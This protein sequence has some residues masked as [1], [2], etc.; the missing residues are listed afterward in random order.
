MRTATVTAWRV[1]GEPLRVERAPRGLD[2]AWAWS[3]GQAPRL[4]LMGWKAGSLWRRAGRVLSM[5]ARFEAMGSAELRGQVATLRDR[6]RLGH[7]DARS[8]ELGLALACEA[9][10]RGVGLRAHRE[11]VMGALAL[12]EGLVA[13]MATGEGKT[14]TA[15]LA[16]TIAGW[17]G[18]GTHVVTVNDYLARRDAAWMKPVYEVCGVTVGVVSQE[19]DTHARRRAYNADVTYTTSKEAAA[20]FLRDRIAIGVLN[21]GGAVAR[22]LIRA[23]SASALNTLEV[24]GAPLQR[25]LACALVDEADSVLIDEAVTPL[26]LSGKGGGRGGD[27]EEELVYREAARIAGEMDLGRDYSVESDRR[28]ARLTEAGRARATARNGASI[29]ARRKEELV[30]QAIE[31]REHYRLGREYVIHDGRVV[32]VDEFTGR[33]MADR[34]WRDGMHQAIEA[35]EGLALR[36]AQET[37]AQ[38]S[39]QRFF[40]LYRR[41]SGMTGTAR[42]AAGELWR[43]YRLAVVRVPTHRPVARRER[44]QV[45]CAHESEKL[46]RVVE[47][48]RAERGRGRPVLIGTRSVAASERVSAALSKAGVEHSVL[49]A[50]RHA[51]EAAVIARAGETGIVTVATNMAGRGT[52]IRLGEGVAALGGLH[53][54]ATERHE[55]LRVDR[56][57]FGRAGRQGDPGS[58]RAI[59]S[60]EDELLVR[61]TPILARKIGKWGG[62]LFG[63]AQWRASGAAARMRIRVLRGD[64][65]L[66]DSLGFAGRDI[67][68]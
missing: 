53:V 45:V 5:W 13:E 30:T 11:Q 52:D 62:W 17:R 68:G 48:A 36:A 4:A 28:R 46:E 23:M 9:A 8:I 21:G 19:T 54:I 33:L 7:E 10:L 63:F 59:V 56:Q 3:V 29:S 60:L 58:A 34:T 65:W 47:E 18:R 49:N 26:I 41:L 50:E 22:N 31:A 27:G 43:T 40:R 35:K 1:M 55:S 14:L 39:F 44:R 42:E 32:I 66:D 67:S 6:F 61:F 37:L 24:S 25:G 15:A 64:D 16:A 51:E 12:A 57:L 2:A 38:I 20:D